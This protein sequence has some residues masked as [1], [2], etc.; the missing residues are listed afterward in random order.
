MILRFRFQDKDQEN[1]DIANL[2]NEVRAAVY[3]GPLYTKYVKTL[4]M[5]YLV[6]NIAPSCVAASAI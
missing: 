2:Q 4:C 6:V 1:D 5:S 3:I